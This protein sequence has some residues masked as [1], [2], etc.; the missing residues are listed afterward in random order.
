V[1]KETSET[2]SDG[3]DLC[4]EIFINNFKVL[5]STQLSRKQRKISK[6]ARKS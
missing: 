1:V 2:N 5:H 3:F 4:A 6:G